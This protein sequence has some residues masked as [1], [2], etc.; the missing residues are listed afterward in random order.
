MRVL[1][2]RLAVLAV[3]WALPA[4]VQAQFT[5]TTNNGAITIAG[6]SGF[7]GEVVIPS[8]VGSLPVTSIGVGAFA[9]L[10]DV[11]SVTIP[12]GVTTIDDRAFMNCGLTRIT[13]PDS[14]TSIGN[15]VFNACPNLSSITIPNSVTNLGNNGFC[16]CFSLT[17]VT[18]GNGVPSIE[19]GS[20]SDCPSLTNLTI[21]S[22]VTNIATL[23]FVSCYGL[24]SVT[25]PDSVTSIGENAFSDCTSLRAVC[26]LGNAPSGDSTVFSDDNATVYYLPGTTGWSPAWSQLLGTPIRLWNPQMQT[27]DGRFGV[28]ANQFGF[29]ITGTPDL[30]VVV[31]AATDLANPTWSPVATKTLASGSAYFSDPEWTNYP[32][33]FYRLRSP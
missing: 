25:I 12:E 4:V 32:A 26:F 23:A 9:S 1:R 6:Y 28:M 8:E 16:L 10:S 20:F 15:Y 18:I 29:N 13:I 27:S 24:T 22:S 31:E 19:D 14:V 5:Y 33:R 3:V 30:V 17:S 11:T 7:G 21:G 2:F